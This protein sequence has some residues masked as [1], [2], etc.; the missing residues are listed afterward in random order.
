VLA[1]LVVLGLAGAGGGGAALA[2]ELTRGPTK[3]EMAAAVQQEIAGRWRRLS[4]GQIFLPTLS[5]SSD[6]GERLTASLVGIAPR[7]GC[8]AALDPAMASALGRLGCVTVLRATYLDASGTLA[9]TVGI[10]VMR[11]AAAASTA[12]V[13]PDGVPGSP[14]AN[15]GVRTFSLPGTVADLFGNPQ[16]AVFSTVTSVGPYVFLYAS[17]YTDGRVI[18]SAASSPA[19]ADLGSGLVLDLEAVMASHG[20]AC[21][22]KDIR[23]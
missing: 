21:T 5:Y 3:A 1:L 7:A 11:S 20:S 6:Y 14:P 22:M 18:G 13:A 9:A 10:V 16:R 2:H 8:A 19:L 12:A 17:G 4:A 15:A 23:C